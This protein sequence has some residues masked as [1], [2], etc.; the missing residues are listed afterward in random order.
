MEALRMWLEATSLAEFVRGNYWAWPT[1]ENAHFLGLAMLV[2]MVGLFDLRMLGLARI[3]SPA[4]FHERFV[5]VGIAG[6]V[7]CLASGLVFFIATPGVY[8]YNPAFYL[9]MLFILLGGLNVVVFNLTTLREVLALGPEDDMP[10]R[11]KVIAAVSLFI[12]IGVICF[13]RLLPFV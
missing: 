5:P 10:L 4:A 13:G 9:K 8:I 3:V 12:W 6:F 1:I 7:L 2:G 11:A